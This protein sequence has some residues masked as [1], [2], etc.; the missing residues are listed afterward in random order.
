MTGRREMTALAGICQE[1]FMTAVFAFHTGKAVV[2][3]AAIEIA[4]DHLVDVES[5]ESLLP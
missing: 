2:Q 5:P 1:I 4:V 3:I